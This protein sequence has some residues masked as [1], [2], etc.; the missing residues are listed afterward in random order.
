MLAGHLYM[1]CSLSCRA[2]LQQSAANKACCASREL[3][4]AALPAICSCLAMR[5]L[6]QPDTLGDD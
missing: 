4:N 6:A 3:T 1:Q 5:S 2:H